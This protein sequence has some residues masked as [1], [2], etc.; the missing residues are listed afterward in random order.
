MDSQERTCQLTLYKA[1][2]ASLTLHGRPNHPAN[3][4]FSIEHTR[5]TVEINKQ[6]C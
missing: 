6:T 2:E 3:A 4:F 1:L 5:Y